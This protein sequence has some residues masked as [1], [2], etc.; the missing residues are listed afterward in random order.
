[1]ASLR[2]SCFPGIGKA[3]EDRAPKCVRVAPSSVRPHHKMGPRPPSSKARKELG[4]RGVSLIFWASNPGQGLFSPESPGLKEHIVDG[5]GAL[6]LSRRQTGCCRPK[7]PFSQEGSR[8]S[9]RRGRSAPEQQQQRRPRDGGCCL[10]GGGGGRLPGCAKCR[11][12]QASFALLCPVRRGSLAGL[13]RD[14]AEPG[15]AHSIVGM[16]RLPERGGVARGG[17]RGSPRSP[18]SSSPLRRQPQADL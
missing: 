2:S 3:G 13:S 5:G 17:P 1:M 12:S 10:G 8:L 4:S 18:S 11:S 15:R 16:R 9:P 7:G 14:G 6:R